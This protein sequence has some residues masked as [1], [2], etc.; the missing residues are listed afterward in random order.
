MTYVKKTGPSI[1][2]R[3]VN[4]RQFSIN[5]KVTKSS[6][7]HQRNC[8]TCPMIVNK[9][10]LLIDGKKV[11]SAPGTFHSYNVIYGIICSL[12]NK[13]YLGRT[14][15]PLHERITEHRIKYYEL[16]TKPTIRFS[17]EF[18]VKDIYNLG[19][20]L[21][22]VHGELDKSSFSSN[23]AV[24]ILMNSSPKSLAVNEH[25]IIHKYKSIKPFG[26]NSNDPFGLNSN[27]PFGLNSNY[28]FGLN[29]N[30]PFGLSSNDPFGLSSNYPFGLS[31]ND[32][33]GLSSNYPFGL[34]SNY[35]FG[36]SSN[37]PFG[38]NSND[39]FGLNSN[40]PFGLNSNDPFGLS[41][42]DPFGLNLNDP[43]GIPLLKI[44]K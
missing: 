7:C 21:I 37:Y 1:K 14:T 10:E 42:N 33:F 26:L 38:L 29:S 39:P 31:S 3:L 15:R 11:K 30:Y 35:P 19:L 4:N 44:C 9:E 5:S 28:P 36:L 43:F 34:S 27:D 41:S 2:N 40:D 23:Y 13:Y 24:T 32:P 17:D 25:L 12:C 22:D 20:H 6:P 8:K 16:L 18:H